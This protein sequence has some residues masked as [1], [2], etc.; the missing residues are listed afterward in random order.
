MDSFTITTPWR[1]L[2]NGEGDSA[3]DDGDGLCDATPLNLSYMVE[4]YKDD[5]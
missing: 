2:C 5:S 4:C 1:D 3:E